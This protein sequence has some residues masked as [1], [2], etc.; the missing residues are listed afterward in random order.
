MVG[1]RMETRFD[2]LKAKFIAMERDNANFGG[3]FDTV[4][5]TVLSM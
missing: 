2:V 3:V 4:K 5:E 1:T